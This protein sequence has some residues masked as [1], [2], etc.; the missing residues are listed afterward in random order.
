MLPIK[1]FN[2]TQG[3]QSCND[4]R[5]KK[6]DPGIRA[7]PRGYIDTE[8]RAWRMILMRNSEAMSRRWWTRPC[9]PQ[10]LD[11][12]GSRQPAIVR[13]CPRAAAEGVVTGV[14]QAVWAENPPVTPKQRPQVMVE[15]ILISS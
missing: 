11:V 4:K 6:I 9:R 10:R 1:P 3:C 14:E 8:I 7:Q 15:V 5:Q 2:C 13:E 12:G